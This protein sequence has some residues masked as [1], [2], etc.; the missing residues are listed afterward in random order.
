MRIILPEP[1]SRIIAKVTW[2][3][4]YVPPQK[5]KTTADTTESAGE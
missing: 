5:E 1:K 2:P 4:G 3:A